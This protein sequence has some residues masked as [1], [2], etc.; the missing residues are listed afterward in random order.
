MT[1]NYNKYPWHIKA[2]KAKE[3]KCRQKWERGSRRKEIRIIFFNLDWQSA[4]NNCFII[5]YLL[6]ASPLDGM[7]E[8]VDMW[9]IY[10][11]T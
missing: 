3:E 7:K 10:I 1:M 8:N 9:Y 4:T 11:S 6:I 2:T 5:Q